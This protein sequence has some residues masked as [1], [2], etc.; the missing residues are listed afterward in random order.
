MARIKYGPE[1]ESGPRPRSWP[2]A[3]SLQFHETGCAF[4]H[5][6][7]NGRMDLTLTADTA[8][9]GWAL[10]GFSVGD[11]HV[12][13]T[14]GSRV[15]TT[16]STAGEKHLVK[17][18]DYS[19]VIWGRGDDT[20]VEGTHRGSDCDL[21]GV[22]DGTRQTINIGTSSTDILRILD[23]DGTDILVQVNSGK[24]AVAQA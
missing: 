1:F 6:D 8:V 9:S 11:S 16:S 17:P 24:L 3:A 22:N 18:L 12:T 4:V 19:D 20:F 10:L 5:V 7:G 23:G 15:F 2:F 21:I 14:S 13:G